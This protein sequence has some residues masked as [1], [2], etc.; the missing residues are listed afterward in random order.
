MKTPKLIVFDLDGTLAESKQRMSAPMSELIAQL[1]ARIPVAVMSGGSWKQFQTQFLAALPHEARLERL[2]LFPTSAA[3]CFV[4]RSGDW[5]PQY[6]RSFTQLEK[7]KIMTAFASAQQEVGW[8]QPPQTWGPQL[9]DR[10]GEITFSALGQQAPL[11][12]KEAWD[13]DKAKRTPLAEA[14]KR[15]LPHYSI[16]INAATSIDITPQGINKA[17]GIHRL[18]E[19][20]SIAPAEM[21]YVGDALDEGGNDSVVIDTGVPTHEVFGP[22]ETAAF[23]ERL[24]QKDRVVSSTV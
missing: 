4:Y 11:D 1:L 13:P 6:D 12:A 2:Y 9:E 16:G 24:L 19:L 7:D 22:E 3:Q 21:L 5:R 18:S 23:I 8:Q 15:R 17:Y 20:T 10:D 14:L